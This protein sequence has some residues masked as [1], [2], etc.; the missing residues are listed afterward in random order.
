VQFKRRQIG[1]VTTIAYPNRDITALTAGSPFSEIVIA[2][3]RERH[4]SLLQRYKEH[5]LIQCGESYGTTD[6][7]GELS[8]EK[9]RF[10]A[11]FALLQSETGPALVERVKQG[12][13]E[14]LSAK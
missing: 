9:A 3:L 4:V 2:D 11:A 10:L 7:G 6:R 1:Y 12:M 13:E 8:K 5:W 14:L